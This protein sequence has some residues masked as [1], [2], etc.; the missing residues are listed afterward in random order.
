MKRPDRVNAAHPER[1]PGVTRNGS[2]AEVTGLPE[3]CEEYPIHWKSMPEDAAA[4]N[5]VHEESCHRELTTLHDSFGD[6]FAN[7]AI[8]FLQD[9]AVAKQHAADIVHARTA[10]IA[11]VSQF[12][13]AGQ[14]QGTSTTALS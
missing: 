6:F 12:M 4:D 5:P 13:T 2:D 14:K 10:A 7:A 9:S 1:A 11:K 8:S 3:T